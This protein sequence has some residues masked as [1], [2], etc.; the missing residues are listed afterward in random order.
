MSARILTGRRVSH[1]AAVI[2]VAAVALT[3]CGS[4]DEGASSSAPK[5]DCPTAAVPVVVSVDQ[6]GD[7]VDQLAGDCGDVTTVFNSS[8]ADPHDYEPTPADNAKFTGAKLVVENGLDYDPWADKAVATLDTKPV[9]VNGGKVVGLENGD[10]PHIW[11]GP[12]YVYR[13]ADTVTAKLERLAPKAAAYFEQRNQSWHASMA[14]YDAE[15]AK[16]KPVAA[17]KTYGA[18]EGIF[19]YMAQSLGLTNDTPAGYQRATANESDPSPGDLNGFER[20]LADDEVGVL[21]YNTQTEGA[22]PE[23]VRSQAEASHVPV[24]DVTESVPPK[25]STFVAWQVSQLKDLATA[26]GA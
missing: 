9:V 21:I 23:Q 12:D 2:V 8:S 18:T 26:L 15:I 4:S 11:Y 13:I 6:W 10:N 3:A 16:I 7:I 1:A 25:F 5:G 20:A 19:D 24:V 14:P 17:G 22:I